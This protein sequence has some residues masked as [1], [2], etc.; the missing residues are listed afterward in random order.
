MGNYCYGTAVTEIP[1]GCFLDDQTGKCETDWN[2]DPNGQP[3]NFEFDCDMNTCTWSGISGN[4]GIGYVCADEGGAPINGVCAQEIWY[5]SLSCCYYGGGGGGG[6][7]CSTTAPAITSVVWA[8]P[9]PAIVTTSWNNGS[10]GQRHSIGASANYFDVRSSCGAGTNC[11]F[12]NSNA[13]SPYTVNKNFS[14]GTIYFFRVMNVAGVCSKDDIETTMSSCDISPSSLTLNEGESAQITVNVSSNPTWISSVDFRSLDTTVATVSPDSDTSW[15]YQTTVTAKQVTGTKT[16]KARANVMVKQQNRNISMACLKQIDV[17]VNDLSP[18][19]TL[20][21]TPV[22]K[23]VTEGANPVIFTANVTPANGSVSSVVFTSSNTSAATVTSPDASSPYTTTATINS[24]VAS[25]QVTTI[26]ARAS[27]GT[28]TCSDTSILTVNDAAAANP[29]WWQVKDGDVS[30]NGDLTS[31]VRAPNY[32]DLAG[33]GG[34]PGIPTYGGTTNLNTSRTDVS[35]SPPFGWL[36]NSQ[37]VASNIFSYNYF[38]NMVPDDVVFNSIDP[39]NPAGSLTGG[40]T[41]SYGYRW[42]KYDGASNGGQPLTLPSVNISGKKV[43]LLVDNAD[44]NITGNVNLADGIGFFMTIV[45]GNINVGT[46]VGGGGPNLEGLYFTDGTFESVGNSQLMVRGSVVANDGANLL[47]DLVGA[48][49][50]NPSEFFEYAPDQIL[51]YPSKLASRKI[52]W[53]EVAP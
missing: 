51:L 19:C 44:L 18:S 27:V 41:L 25:T 20:S 37:S 14:I 30:T 15:R 50:V 34:F 12:S 22:T 4:V 42:F 32:F 36:A 31:S 29:A 17:T 38:A 40:A 24:N 2:E 9:R 7:G 5:Q 21:L 1:S 8:L 39:V 10:G 43:I 23:T 28:A 35:Q 33:S 53:K 45:K 46:T 52:S 47:R 16:T 3:H 26:T 49:N 11:I 13:T 48:A 6:G